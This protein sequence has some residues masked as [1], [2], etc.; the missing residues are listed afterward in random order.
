MSEFR[1]WAGSSSSSLGASTQNSHT[2][3]ESIHDSFATP[4]AVITRNNLTQSGKSQGVAS[5]TNSARSVINRSE[6][7]LETIYTSSIK[8]TAGSEKNHA[9]TNDLEP[10]LSAPSLTSASYMQRFE[11]GAA[12]LGSYGS[13]GSGHSGASASLSAGSTSDNIST[14]STKAT[15]G[16]ARTRTSTSTED[17]LTV[18]ET[19]SSGRTTDVSKQRWAVEASPMSAQK[20]QRGEP[21]TATMLTSG[22]RA[23]FQKKVW[24]EFRFVILPP[25]IIVTSQK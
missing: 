20:L 9:S 18:P 24:R 17:E 21:V 14:T 4:S 7:M 11:H 2:G 10:P 3:R 1:R 23:I 15:A 5:T 13:N 8:A 16:S 12:S 19:P 22:L 25:F 6:C